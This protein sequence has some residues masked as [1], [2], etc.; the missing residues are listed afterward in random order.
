MEKTKKQ[1]SRTEILRQTLDIKKQVSDTLAMLW[2]CKAG[3][4]VTTQGNL[5]AQINI[6]GNKMTKSVQSLDNIINNI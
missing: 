6:I 2:K 3:L 1:I 5:I 4:D